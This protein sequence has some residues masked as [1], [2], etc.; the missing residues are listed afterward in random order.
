VLHALRGSM[1]RAQ[2]NQTSMSG[3][4]MVSRIN[5]LSKFSTACGLFCT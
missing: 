5:H 2:L 4:V 1:A 3:Y